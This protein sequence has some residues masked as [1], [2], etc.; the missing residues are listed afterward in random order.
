MLWDVARKRPG[1]GGLA[2]DLL[3]FG[4]FLTRSVLGRLLCPRITLL[5][6]EK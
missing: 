2:M 6:H 5:S 4:Y 3:H 1:M